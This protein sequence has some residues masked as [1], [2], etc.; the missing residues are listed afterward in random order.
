MK[1]AP[2]LSARGRTPRKT[3]AWFRR[4]TGALGCLV[5]GAALPGADFQLGTGAVPINPPPGIGLAGYYHERGNDGVLD[6]LRDRK[7]TRLNSSH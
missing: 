7:S 4:L 1:P 2:Q 5:L 3:P 6:D